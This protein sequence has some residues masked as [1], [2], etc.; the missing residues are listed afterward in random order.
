MEDQI[1]A[2]IEYLA[3]QRRYAP[4]TLLAYRNDL[5]QLCQFVQ[6]ER[7]GIGSWSHVDSVLLQAYLLQLK[8]R[9]Y[10]AASIARKVAACKSFYFYLLDNRAIVNNPAESLEAP[11]V[12]KHLPRALTEDQVTALLESASD[13]TP[14]GARDR[15]MLEVL[16]AVGLRVT[17][18]VTLP[19][20]ALDL[21]AGTLRI[22]KGKAERVLA[23]SPRALAA[24]RLYLEKGRPA[25]H[26]PDTGGPLFVNSRGSHLTRQG[27]W[28]ILKDYVRRAGIAGEVT[29]HSLRHAFAAHRLAQGEQVQELQRLLGHAHLST[30]LMYNRSREEISGT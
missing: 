25:L 17:E 16:Y 20:E 22:E 11:S 19:I 4:N 13:A 28:L 18:L 23:L 5:L 12:P 29:P 21:S 7:P 30:T 2:F 14:K 27:V 1:Q 15:A 9:D 6:A 24:L 26:G 3:T 10:S 8:S